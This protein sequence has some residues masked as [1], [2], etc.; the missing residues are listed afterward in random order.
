MHQMIAVEDN[1]KKKKFLL[2]YLKRMLYALILDIH[3]V[4]THQDIYI[5]IVIP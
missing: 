1:V 2:Q 5:Y 3:A 4:S